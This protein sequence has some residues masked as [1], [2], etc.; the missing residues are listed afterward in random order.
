MPYVYEEKPHSGIIVDFEQGCTTGKSNDKVAL[1]LCLSLGFGNH[2]LPAE[3][4]GRN[5]GTQSRHHV[6]SLQLAAAL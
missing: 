6:I 2:G 5:H 3:H 1:V 4:T